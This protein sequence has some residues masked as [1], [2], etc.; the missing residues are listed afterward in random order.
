MRGVFGAGVAAAFEKN[1]IY[2]RVEAIYCASAGVMTAAYFIARQTEFGASIYWE[3]LNN[4]FISKKDFAIGVWQ[5]FQSKF[6]RHVPDHRLHDAV[7]IDYLIDVV[8]N[9]K[10]LKVE[11]ILS[12][13]IPINVKL[14]NLDSH[15][16]EYIDARRPDIF[17]VLRAGLNVF[18]YV[19]EVS[20]IDNK[21]LIDAA[22]IDIIGAEFLRK[23]H[24]NQ[25]IIVV[26]NGQVDRK[27]RYRIKNIIEGKFMKW[28]FDDNKL[29]ELYAHAEDKLQQDLQIIKSDPNFVLVKPGEEIPVLSRTTDKERL[30]YTYNLGLKA[31]QEALKKIWFDTTI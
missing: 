6:I 13:N 12:Q 8:R 24:P 25:K 17:E 21:K 18:P 11:K 15:S 26:M 29:Y 4:S 14:F 3:N 16:I 30:L 5:R 10:I 27:L 20:V 2:E 31:S 22:I 23:K 28:M 9:K 1:N 7:N 19:H